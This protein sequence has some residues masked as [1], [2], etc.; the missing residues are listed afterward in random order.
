MGLSQYDGNIAVRQPHL[1]CLL[2][3]CGD[4]ALKCGDLP[5]YGRLE[6]ADV[7]TVNGPVVDINRQMDPQTAFVLVVTSPRQTGNGI[8]PVGGALVGQRGEIK[9]GR[10]GKIDQSVGLSFLV[11][12]GGLRFTARFR[13]GAENG[14]VLLPGHGNDLK[15]LRAGPQGRKTRVGPVEPHHVSAANTEPEGRNRID[16]FRAEPDHQKIE[17]QTAFSGNRLDPGDFYGD[18]DGVKGPLYLRKERKGVPAGPGVQVDLFHEINS[19]L[20]Q[21]VGVE[22]HARWW[23]TLSAVI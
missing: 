5:V 20:F 7:E 23:Y 9:P 8:V 13:V 11:E 4:F 18:R 10:A 19:F 14:G 15:I 1:F 16:R 21:N 6:L 3:L 12:E 22:C 17:G 2:E